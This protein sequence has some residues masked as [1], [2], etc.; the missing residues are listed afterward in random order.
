ML[1]C[2]CVSDACGIRIISG[3][4]V[5]LAADALAQ[6]ADTWKKESN[7]H[8]RTCNLT[9]ARECC[10]QGVKHRR[11]RVSLACGGWAPCGKRGVS[12]AAR[13]AFEPDS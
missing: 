3:G 12:S 7:M 4:G 9:I 1:V 6:R 11:S 2:V 13:A 8:L 5:V 10:N